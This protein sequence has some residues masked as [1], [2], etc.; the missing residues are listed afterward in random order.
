MRWGGTME[1]GDAAQLITAS[2][3]LLVALGGGIVWIMKRLDARKVKRTEEKAIKTVAA[4]EETARRKDEEIEAWR[5]RFA[6]LTEDYNRSREIVA[7]QDERLKR[8]DERIAHL[9][10]LC[11]TRGIRL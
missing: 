6:Q 5:S 2:T 9:E 7:Q 11:D 8:K 3:G 10:N 1:T 4:W